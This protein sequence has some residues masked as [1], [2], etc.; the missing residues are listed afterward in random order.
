[1]P[2]IPKNP[3]SLEEIRLGL[4]TSA[5]EFLGTVARN[6][7]GESLYSFL[8][9]VSC[10]GFSA[11]GA[12]ATEEA[13][14][15]FAEL[16]IANGPRVRSKN[17]LEAIKSAYRWGS[18]EDAWYQKPDSAFKSVNKLL[19]QAEKQKLYK[20]YDGTLTELCL[21]VLR[22]MDDDAFFGRGEARQTVVLGLCYTGGDNSDEEFL[23]WARHVN[24]V[25]VVDRLQ[26]EITRCRSASN[27]LHR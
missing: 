18:I 25:K 17:P 23:D 16:E 27:Q 6:Q 21:Q 22:E 26:E 15:R 13:L 3:V 9:E 5:E 10:E 20:L 7:P 4:R 14:T 2:I 24:P 12:A 8:F 11:H 1:V 19:R